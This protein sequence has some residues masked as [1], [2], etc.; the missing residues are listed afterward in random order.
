[1]KTVEIVEKPWGH[2][3]IW[4]KT[5]KYIG[6][7]L[8]INPGH[9]LSLQYHEFK[10]ETLMV[11]NG[12]LRIWIC[13]DDDDYFDICPGEVYHV[14]PRQVHRFGATKFQEVTV[15]EVSTPEIDD[16]VRITDDYN[17]GA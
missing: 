7:I 9:R 17:R 15:V 13:D 4:A 11:L 12:T 2:E 8:T 1:M 5:D 10:E 14:K 3:K 16:V 6:K